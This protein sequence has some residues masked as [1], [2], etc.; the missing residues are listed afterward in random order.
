MKDP[1]PCDVCHIGTLR[2]QRQTY[3]T[4]YDGHLI[5]LPDVDT[6][7][8]DV[9]GEFFYDPTVIARVDW[10]LGTQQPMPP[11]GTHQGSSKG[12]G[13]AVLSSGRRRSA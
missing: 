7:L 5:L 13:T 8:C 10:L 11:S 9:C 12:M 3:A 1:K 6:W 4:W 2:P